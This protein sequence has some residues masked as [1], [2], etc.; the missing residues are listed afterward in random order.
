MLETPSWSAGG[1]W[2]NEDFIGIEG[3][4]KYP[5]LWYDDV[6]L[7]GFHYADS[8]IF[9]E[10]WE[11]RRKRFNMHNYVVFK[12]LY[13][14]W[15]IQNFRKINAKKL[16]IYWGNGDMKPDGIISLGM[17]EAELYE[18]GYR[19]FI[20]NVTMLFS[21]GKILYYYDVFSLLT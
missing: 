19:N 21:T 20:N 18:D 3:K 16:G 14:E 4:T 10:K 11:R 9:L 8:A 7:H 6:L 12:C 17:E 5:M 2:Q 15:D 13:D 1:I